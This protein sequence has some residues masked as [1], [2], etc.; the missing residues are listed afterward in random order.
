MKVFSTS[1]SEATKLK[2]TLISDIVNL[3]VDE[4]QAQ[5][6]SFN[7]QPAIPRRP[8]LEP[9]P[10]PA[11]YLAFLLGLIGVRKE[12]LSRFVLAPRWSV[13]GR[14]ASA[15]HDHWANSFTKQDVFF[16]ANYCPY[17]IDFL[18][19]CI[20]QNS[21]S[22]DPH[23]YKYDR[24]LISRIRYITNS[25]TKYEMSHKIDFSLYNPTIHTLVE[26]CS[27]SIL[28]CQSQKIYARS[29]QFPILNQIT[30]KH[31]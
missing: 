5:R 20:Y 3:I 16:V 24:G 18:L 11:P 29:L 9:A 1:T 26:F 22:H 4:Q 19:P 8:S 30:D 15:G 10:K 23:F 6:S 31:P 13:T 17:Y 14:R 12:R 27:Q 2:L 28:V 21:A 25:F 7:I